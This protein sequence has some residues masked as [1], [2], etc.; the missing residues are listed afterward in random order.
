MPRN[1]RMYNA[2][3]GDCFV[4]E[5]ANID[6]NLLV[7]CGIHRCSKIRGGLRHE[8]YTRQILDDIASKY[9][10][11]NALITHFHYDHISG[12]TYMF[13]NSYKPLNIRTA[14]IPD[15]WGSS[16]VVATSLLEELMVYLRLSRADL[17]GYVSGTRVGLLDLL[18]FLCGNVRDIRFLRR[19]VTFP[20]EE[21]VTLLPDDDVLKRVKKD[22]EAIDFPIEFRDYYDRIT[23]LSERIAGFVQQNLVEFSVDLGVE[24][25]EQI[26]SFAEEF[27]GIVDEAIASTS[28]STNGASITRTIKRLNELG[29]EISIVFQNTKSD[30]ENVI[31]TGDADKKDIG[32]IARLNDIPLHDNYKYVKIPHHGTKSHF[33]D[34][35]TNELKPRLERELEW[36]LIPSGA[37]GGWAR[38]FGKISVDYGPIGNSKLCSN[39]DW[40]E[41]CLHACIHMPCLSDRYLVEPD[42]SIRI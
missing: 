31:F 18:G 4:L 15:I 24:Y 22:F 25:E 5:D 27:N 12:L 8:D 17:P 28:S 40:C 29:N 23:L 36:C 14:Y 26:R 38:K 9:K 13:H 37:V 35:S 34:F 32:R 42:L 7:D 1:V 39:A 33:Y 6:M 3:F 20:Q 10:E 16:F 11:L 2:Y 21:Y 41:C 30:Q 19:G